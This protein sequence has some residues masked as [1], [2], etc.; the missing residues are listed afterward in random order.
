MLPKNNAGFFLTEALLSLSAVLVLIGG[1]LPLFLHLNYLADS[2]KQES[3]AIH[4]LYD[5]LEN[6][7]DESVLT[8]NKVVH[9]NGTNFEIVW[10]EPMSQTEVCVQ[11][12]DFYEKLQKKCKCPIE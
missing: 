4:L 7:L 11:Y 3:M 12:R 10:N 8:G 5:E 2:L 1:L 9:L 6:H